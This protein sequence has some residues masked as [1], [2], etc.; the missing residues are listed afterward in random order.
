MVD[1][2]TVHSKKDIRI[3]FK[4]GTEIKTYDT[5]TKEEFVSIISGLKKSKSL[6]SPINQRGKAR[7]Q[8]PNGNVNSHSDCTTLVYSNT[9][10]ICPNTIRFRWRAANKVYLPNFTIPSNKVKQV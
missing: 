7:S 2:I 10:K 6:K 3:T 5:L 1:Y 9:A 4:Y 8:L